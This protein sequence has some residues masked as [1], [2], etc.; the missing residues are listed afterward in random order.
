ME[1]PPQ[2]A[3]TTRDSKGVH[4]SS[5]TYWEGRPF[6]PCLDGNCSLYV[7]PLIGCTMSIDKNPGSA[8]SGGCIGLTMCGC[9]KH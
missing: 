8:G 2:L 9:S 6:V 1:P 5:F 4:W 3:L 7:N